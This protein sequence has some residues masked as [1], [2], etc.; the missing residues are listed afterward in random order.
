MRST[1]V[2]TLVFGIGA[3]NLVVSAYVSSQ[4][5]NSVSSI[6]VPHRDPASVAEHATDGHGASVDAHGAPASGGHGAPAAGGHG[7]A[8]SAATAGSSPLR[9]WVTL[10][11]MYVNVTSQDDDVHTLA[12]KLEVELFEET[13][14]HQMEDRQAIIK[15]AIIEIARLQPYES[16]KSLAGKLYF[17]EALVSQVNQT[18]AFPLIRDVHLSTFSLR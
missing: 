4:A 5:W 13:A 8:P 11:E 15:N 17:K 6:A 10:E 9:S 3:M 1:V 7:A 2:K 18:V 12:F 14:R 16:L